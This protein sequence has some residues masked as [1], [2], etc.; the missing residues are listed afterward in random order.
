MYYKKKN[1]ASILI[2]NYNKEKF[3]KKSI[4]SCL[5]QNFK[6]KE[7]I[8]FDDCSNDKSLKILKK[9][10]KIK[11]IKNKKKKYTSGPLNQIYGLLNAFEKSKGE[12]I[13][14][15]DSDDEFKFNKLSKVYKMFKADRNLKFIQDTPYLKSFK[16][17]A[18]LKNKKSLFTIWPSFFPTSCIAIRKNFLNEFFKVSMKHDFSNLEID[19]RLSI[20]AFLK[21]E[22]KVTNEILTYYNYDQIGITSRYKKFSI[23][24]WKKRKEA[25]E[26]T[27]ILTKKLKLNFYMGP[28]YF[29]TQIINLFFNMFCK[30]Y[31]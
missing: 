27:R 6:N 26:Y 21:N 28:D 9:F 4:K 23:L 15:L 22:F 29:I 11:L 18:K 8:I 14:L 30:G 25:F 17:V 20:F 16:K 1:L 2:T 3:L 5:N 12:I 7:I 19:A 31:H 13:F 24:W 10:S